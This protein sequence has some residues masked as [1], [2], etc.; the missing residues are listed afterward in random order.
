MSRVPVM[1]L[2]E[3]Y[4]EMYFVRDVLAPYL[5]NKEVDAVGIRIGTNGHKGGKISFDRALPNV[6]NLLRQRG[7]VFVTTMFDFYGLSQGW[8]GL[9]QIPVNIGSSQKAELLEN[10]VLQ[11]MESLMRDSERGRFIPYFSMHEFEGMLFSD[12]E[13][14]SCNME[15]SIEDLQR[16]AGAFVSPEDINNSPATAP[17]KRLEALDSSYDKV[18]AGVEVARAIGIDNIRAKCPHFNAWLEKLEAL[19]Q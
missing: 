2:C 9:D 11:E 7:N 8:P 12:V 3:G 4:T 15:A 19:A 13:V 14:L 5:A 17:S 6:T 10:A 1:V 16:I 18:D